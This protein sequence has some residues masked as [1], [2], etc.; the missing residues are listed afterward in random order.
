MKCPRC[1]VEVAERYAC[2]NCGQVIG[3]KC[4]LP[5]CKGINPLGAQFCGDCGFPFA[6]S[7]RQWA[8]YFGL[9]QQTVGHPRRNVIFFTTL[10][11]ALLSI[12]LPTL[13][14][15]NLRYLLSD[16]S[17]VLFVFVIPPIVATF[18]L[19]ATYPRG[20]LIYAIPIGVFFEYMGIFIVGVIKYN[21][22]SVHG[23]H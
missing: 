5:H 8:R 7:L 11:T 17:G 14:W 3:Q 6:R 9:Y 20:R 19:W 12:I 10:A 4:L 23:I 1:A 18:A 15:G 21:L 22:S 13:I 16:L 2:T